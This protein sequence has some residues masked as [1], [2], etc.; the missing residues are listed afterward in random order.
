MTKTTI[1][2]ALFVGA[3]VRAR[4]RAYRKTFYHAFKAIKDILRA[5]SNISNYNHTPTVVRK[6]PTAALRALRTR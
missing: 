3:R 5:R 4:A 6:P 2:L 1:F